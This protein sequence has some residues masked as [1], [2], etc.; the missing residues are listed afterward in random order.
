[1]GSTD[2][3]DTVP[4]NKYLAAGT[5][6]K[7][8]ITVTFDANSTLSSDALSALSGKTA[9]FTASFG[10]EQALANTTYTEL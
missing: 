9:I 4:T 10:F 5:N 7:V 3:T 8:T 6:K 2:L 1:M